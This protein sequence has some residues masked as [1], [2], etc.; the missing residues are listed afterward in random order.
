MILKTGLDLSGNNISGVVNITATGII[1][2]VTPATADDSTKAATTAFVKAQGY[3]TSVAWGDL[4]G[5]QPAPV[6][7]THGTYDGF[8]ALSG[9]TILSD[10]GVTN[11]I[12]SSITTRELTP[13]NIGAPKLTVTALAPTGGAAG[14]IHVNTALATVYIHDGTAWQGMNTYQ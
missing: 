13:A 2:L 3:L 10:I 11:G 12:M 6:T 8:A 7:H 4:T 1:T 5:T 9:A 14:D